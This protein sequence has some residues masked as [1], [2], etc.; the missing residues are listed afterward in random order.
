MDMDEDQNTLRISFPTPEEAKEIWE[1][2]MKEVVSRREESDRRRN[3][4]LLRR[5]REILR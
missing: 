1:E 5:C 4:D 3:E 2:A